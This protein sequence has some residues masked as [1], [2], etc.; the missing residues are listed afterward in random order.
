MRDNN[1]ALARQF[2]AAVVAPEYLDIYNQLVAG[3]RE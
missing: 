3:E 1:L 2:D